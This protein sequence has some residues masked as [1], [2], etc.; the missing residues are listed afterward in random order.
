MRIKIS[1]FFLGLLFLLLFFGL[2]NLQVMQYGKFSELS[3]KNHIRLLP[4]PGARGRILDRNNQVIVDNYLTFDVMVLSPEKEELDRAIFIIARTLGVNPAELKKIYRKNYSAPFIPV[5]LAKNI[6]IKKAVALEELKMDYPGIVIQQRPVRHYAYGKLAC[7]AVGYLNEI[8]QWRLSKLEDYGYRP[9][10]LVGYGGVEE[11]Y[12]YYLREEEGALSVEVDHRGKFVRTLGFRPAKDGKDI[13]LTVDLGIQKIVENSL[14]ERKGSVVVMDPNSGEIIAMVS[15]PRYNPE[16]FVKKAASSL[17]GI[18]TNSDSVLMN[19]AISGA[20]APGSVFKLVVATAALE[21]NK[22]NLGTSFFCPGGLLVGNRRFNCWNTHNQQDLIQAIA[23]SCD[24]FF[25]HTGIL[26]GAA[27]IHDYALRFGFS[28]PTSIDLPY[29]VGGFVPNPRWKKAYRSQV[30]YDGDTAN[31]SIGQG[32]LLTTPLQI[33][34]MV[35]VFAN[36]GF[37]VNPYIVKAIGGQDITSYQKGAKPLG[38]KEKFM[39]AIRQGELKVVTDP[40]GTANV[41][42]GLAV[43]VAGKTGTAQ[44]ARSQPHGWFCGFF[45]FER[46]KFA[47]CVFLESGGSGYGACVIT[48]QIIEEMLKQGLV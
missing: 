1:T 20:Y 33:T 6:E 13:Q 3:R 23:H 15:A 5:T 24:V 30:W 28:K 35:S 10:D 4:Q 41:L 18:F 43:T 27:G 37:L 8:D 40:D 25:Y 45:P 31:F 48:K 14:G 34:R 22:I 2:F 32:D 16:V 47:I 36:R 42:S 17:A 29:E 46:P 7:H 39:N 11:K 38:I 12:D 26:L 9:K 21:A 44:V 19:R